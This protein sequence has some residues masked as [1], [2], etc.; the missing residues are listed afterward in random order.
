M[1]LDIGR[2][3][4]ENLKPQITVYIMELLGTGMLFLIFNLVISNFDESDKV[5]DQIQEN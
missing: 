5:N 3:E 4:R 2:Q 1:E